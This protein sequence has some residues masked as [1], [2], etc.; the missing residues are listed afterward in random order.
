MPISYGSYDHPL[1]VIPT[2]VSTSSE[3]VNGL[4]EDASSSHGSTVRSLQTASLVGIGQIPHAIGL[5][6]F[7]LSSGIANVSEST[8]LLLDAAW[9]S[10]TRKA[11]RSAWK[12]WSGWCMERELDP[13][14]APV[15]SILSFITQHFED[16]SL[17]EPLMVIGRQF[18]HLILDLMVYLLVNAL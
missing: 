9:S 13:S 6:T 17:I 2:V 5:E 8:R 1:L 12:Y 18:H 15:E 3:V 14:S 7:R 10:G 16:D 4:S 11:Y